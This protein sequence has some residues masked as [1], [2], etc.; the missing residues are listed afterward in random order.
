MVTQKDKGRQQLFV[1]I[2]LLTIVCFYFLATPAEYYWGL[3]IF[4][5]TKFIIAIPFILILT[6]STRW[7]KRNLLRVAFIALT[8]IVI[9]YSRDVSDR[10]FLGKQLAY[11]YLGEDAGFIELY[12]FDSGKCKITYGGIFGVRETHYGTYKKTDKSIVVDTEAD[13]ADLTRLTIS[14]QDKELK[15]EEL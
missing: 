9:I 12:L 15:I 4:G 5:W 6:I 3:H 7:T 13:I 2:I 8:I 1:P 11:K 10:A 14:L